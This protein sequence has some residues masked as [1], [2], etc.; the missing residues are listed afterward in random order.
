MATVVAMLA[1]GITIHEIVAELPD[2]TTDDVVESLRFAAE[3]VREREL[4]LRHM[5]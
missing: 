1:D 5:A 2:L 3:A 4:P